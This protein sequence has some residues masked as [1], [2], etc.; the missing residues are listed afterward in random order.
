MALSA[1]LLVLEVLFYGAVSAANAAAMEAARRL[2]ITGGS[3]GSLS[4]TSERIAEFEV[5]YNRIMSVLGNL[6]GPTKFR[7]LACNT[8]TDLA[9]TVGGTATSCSEK[10]PGQG[11]QFVYFEANYSHKP[12][13]GNTLC[14]FLALASWSTADLS[15]CTSGFPIRTTIVRRNEPF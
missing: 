10:D 5:E 11:G 1:I 2:S 3:G 4:K 13:S 15:P 12:L 7:Y 9:N 6:G 14:T 8:T